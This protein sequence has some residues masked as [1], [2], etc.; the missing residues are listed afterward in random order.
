[1]AH[2]VATRPRTVKCTPI[3]THRPR[4]EGSFKKLDVN[5]VV[6]LRYRYRTYFVQGARKVLKHTII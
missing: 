6:K 1:M 2:M 4:F 3:L 5:T